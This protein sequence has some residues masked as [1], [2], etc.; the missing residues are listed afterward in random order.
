MFFVWIRL[1]D[2]ARLSFW[3][4]AAIIPALM[5]ALAMLFNEPG[6][7]SIQIGLY[8]S[9]GL[10]EGARIEES[11]RAYGGTD[12]TL[13]RYYDRESLRQDVAN[14]R[15]ELG[16]VFAEEGI[17]LYSSA[18]AVTERVTNLLV[19]AAYLE[20]VAGEL[21]A[22]VLSFFMEADA[23][24]IQRRTEGYLADGPLMSRLTVLHGQEI[25]T[26]PAA[27]FRRLFHGLL[28][29]FAQLLAMICSMGMSGQKEKQILH[30]IRILGQGKGLL[31][32]F[33][34]FLAVLVMTGAVMA[35]TVIICAS[36][37][38]GL[39]LGQDIAA[40]LIYLIVICAISVALAMTLPEGLMPAFVT[41]S[42]IFTALMGAVIFDLSEVFES[43]AFLAYLFPSHYYMMMLY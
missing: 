31:Y 26:A 16:Y 4:A 36:A 35:F 30:R 34:G 42:F 10:P 7:L 5:L 40:A 23:L 20:T 17:N 25:T 28:I 24:E 39:W 41:L 33:S 1:K 6:A 12:W 21:G 8:N 38:P 29:L 27:P 43:L 2:R 3:L 13:L 11:L 32:V 18:A 22:G 14:R 9:A 37:F 15:L 19:A